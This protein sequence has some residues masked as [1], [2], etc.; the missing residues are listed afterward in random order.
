MSRRSASTRILTTALIL[1][2]VVA[3]E[4]PNLAAGLSHYWSFDEVTCNGGVYADLTGRLSLQ[5][6]ASSAAAEGR[7]GQGISG[8]WLT[9]G[10]CMPEPADMT[11]SAWVWCDP[12]AGDGC[13]T[14]ASVGNHNHWTFRLVD[15]KLSFACDMSSDIRAAAKMPMKTWAHVA[16]T[17]D[18]ADHAPGGPKQVRLWLDGVEVAAGTMTWDASPDIFLISNSHRGGNHP[19]GG[20]ID[21]AGMWNRALKPAEIALLHG[22]GK[23]IGELLGPAQTVWAD[24]DATMPAEEGRVPTHFHVRRT[25]TAG[26]LT[27]QLS[28]QGWADATRYEPLPTTVI[29]PNG[30]SEVAIELRPVDEAITQGR[31]S[32]ILH[33]ERNARYTIRPDAAEAMTRIID[34]DWKDIPKRPRKIY[35]HY[36]GCFCAGTGA[37]QWHATS[38][39]GTMDAP[40]EAKKR[41]TTTLPSGQTVVRSGLGAWAK[42]SVGGTYRNFGLAPYGPQLPLEVAAD[43][44]IRRAM[45]IGIDGFTFDAWAGGSG[46]LQLFEAMLKICEEKDYP[47]E[48]TITPDATCLGD[49]PEF[50]PYQG[51]GLRKTLRWLIDRHGKSPKLARRDGKLLLFGYGA[52]WAW[53]GHLWEVAGKKIGPG[54]PS[55]EYEREVNRLRASPEGW[56]LIPEAYHQIEQDIGQPLYWQMDLAPNL[57]GHGVGDW[58]DQGDAGKATLAAVRLIAPEVPIL[59]QFLGDGTTQEQAKITIAAGKEWSHPIFLQYENYGYFQAASRGLDTL[60]RNWEEAREIPSTL[61]QYITWNDYHES[62]NLSPGYNTRYAYYDLTGQF[63]RWWKSGTPPTS[64]HDRLYIFSHKYAQKGNTWPFQARWFPDNVIE[65]VAILPKPGRLRMPGRTALDGS[66]EWDAPAGMSFKQFPLVPGPVALE[67]LR[68]GKTV[69]HLD[70]DEPVGAWPFRPDVGKCCASTEDDRLWREDFGKDVPVFHYSEYGDVDHDGLP[71]WFEML[72]FGTW[73][74]MSTATVADPKADADGDGVSN[75]DE[76]LHQTDPTDPNS[77]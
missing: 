33:L 13:Q 7:F 12:A 48:L 38:G 54:R 52:Q 36:M 76:Y 55:A 5:R 47:F 22:S 10:T 51:D 37:I 9:G 17:V 63:I 49:L 50:K 11:F 67:L 8:N 62:T 40:D 74:D 73:G 31:E 16:A 29:I 3:A 68:G 15:Q 58:G 77:K 59:G 75:L 41:E 44:E 24:V 20:R 65:V 42:G 26:D 70:N 23:P 39:L 27:V 32:V 72:Y 14:I 43:L 34:N 6:E 28:W 46:A 60:R 66:T 69:I 4:E 2:G 25:G 19:F 61:I 1:G 30:R 18:D 57:F 53:V 64:D 71:N 21:D 56:K 35:A 45:R